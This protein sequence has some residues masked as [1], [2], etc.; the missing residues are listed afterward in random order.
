MRS[1]YDFFALLILVNFAISQDEFETN[2]VVPDMSLPKLGNPDYYDD[3]V[4]YLPSSPHSSRIE[5]TF[6]NGQS[7]NCQKVKNVFWTGDTAQKLAPEDISIVA[8]MGDSLSTGLNLWQNSN[9]EF[10]GAVFTVG[11]DAYL[12]GLITIPSILQLFNKDLIGEN[13][14]MQTNSNNVPAHQ[15]NV[16]ISGSKQDSLVMQADKLIAKIKQ[17]FDHEDLEKKWIMIFVTLGSEEKCNDCGKADSKVILLMLQR[18]RRSLPKCLVV[19]IGPLYVAPL[20]RPNY[21]IMRSRCPCLRKLHETDLLA[22]EDSW[23]KEFESVERQVAKRK[24]KHFGVVTIP[25]LEV[26]TQN[27]EAYLI[28]GKPLLNRKGHSFAA[29]WLW[30]RLIAGRTYNSSNIPVE[31]D[32]YYCPPLDC[33]YFK[34][35]RNQMECSVKTIKQHEIDLKEASLAEEEYNRQHANHTHDPLEHLTSSQKFVRNHLLVVIFSIIGICLIIICSLTVVFYRHGQNQ[36]KGRFENLP[37]A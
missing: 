14:G 37:G 18:L 34:L 9:V 1:V 20:V 35:L 31:K 10:R 26:I 17:I 4:E 15:F 23:K 2:N 7:F 5:K 33:P 24:F 8:G 29:K 21:D 28:N 12:D 13:H 27:P 3:S 25:R 32:S 6:T 16:A 22:L 19:L 30:N 11:G 36:T